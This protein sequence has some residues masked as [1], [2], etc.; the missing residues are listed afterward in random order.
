MK[1]DTLEL[2]RP[3]SGNYVL[4]FLLSLPLFCALAV[5]L[6]S[7]PTGIED[8]QLVTFQKDFAE[9]LG[10]AAM[11]G[12]IGYSTLM[13]IFLA[14]TS[15]TGY[16][17]KIAAL[18]LIVCFPLGCLGTGIDVLV[19]NRPVDALEVEHGGV[20]HLFAEE[21]QLEKKIVL[22]LGIE[23]D[24]TGIYLRS[25]I[26]AEDTIE[27][28][29][30]WAPVV[31]TGVLA[32]RPKPEI[33]RSADMSHLLIVEGNRLYLTFDTGS[34]LL[35]RGGD[36]FAVIGPEGDFNEKSGKEFLEAWLIE[37]DWPGNDGAGGITVEHLVEGSK[38]PNAKV[39]RLVLRWIEGHP[40]HHQLLR[41][42]YQTLQLDPEVT[43]KPPVDPGGGPGGNGPG[44][45]GPGGG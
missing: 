24:S 44:G 16:E 18:W 3:R 7:R 2:A 37:Q 19:P 6:L 23:E 43:G 21:S 14:F 30:P 5:Y 41:E 13:G 32:K 10:L 1:D 40:K 4:D 9:L 42:T 38:H 20:Y 34:A 22:K 26:V 17:K 45:N 28:E 27:V 36:P 8:G 15:M 35:Q 11:V 29:K 25:R 12:G 39:R 31:R 33:V